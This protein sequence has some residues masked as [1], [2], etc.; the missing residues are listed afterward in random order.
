MTL[1]LIKYSFL[2]KEHIVQKIHLNIL[3]DTMIM[4]LLDHYAQVFHK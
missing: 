3:L 4:M 1:I 2:K